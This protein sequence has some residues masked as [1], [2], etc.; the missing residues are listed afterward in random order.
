MNSLWK[1]LRSLCVV[2][3]S[4]PGNALCLTLT[5]TRLLRQGSSSRCEARENKEEVTTSQASE[6]EMK[7]RRVFGW[8][9]KTLAFTEE[10]VL[11]CQSYAEVKGELSYMRVQ[12]RVRAWRFG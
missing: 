5:R 11:K 3:R 8:G 2:L 10:E 6:M 7:A 4:C 1:R 12:T 9:I